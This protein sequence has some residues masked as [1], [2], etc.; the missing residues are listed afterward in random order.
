MG[1][2]LLKDSGS[3]LMEPFVVEV[4]MMA[5][6]HKQKGNDNLLLMYGNLAFI[7][8]RRSNAGARSDCAYS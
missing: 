3:N 1:K 7:L 6:D 8:G 2:C 5:F 4:N